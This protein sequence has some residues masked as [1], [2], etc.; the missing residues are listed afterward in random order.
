MENKAVESTPKVNNTAGLGTPEEY[1][2]QWG[3]KKFCKGNKSLEDEEHSGRPQKLTMTNWDQSLKLILI[4]LPK[5]VASE[6]NVNYSMIIWHLKQIGK[7]RKLDKCLPCELPKNKKKW[8]EVS[9]SLTTCN[10][11]KPFLDWIVTWWKVDFIRQPVMTSS[12]AGLRSSSKSL[13][14]AKLAPKK[15]HRH[16]WWSA[17]HLIHYSFP[18]PS[19]TIT[20]DCS[21]NRWGAPKTATPAA[22]TGHQKGPNSPPRQHLSAHHTTD[23]SKAVQTGLQSFAYLP[24]SLDL[25]PTDYHFKHLNG[26][27]QGKCFHSQQE[28]EN[29]FQEFVGSRGTDF[30]T[31]GIN[32]LISSW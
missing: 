7:V 26:F 21:A 2:V 31:T 5:K 30:Y 1:M 25:L 4:Q 18:N 11:N 17:A 15:G 14:I 6:L 13:P 20:S 16:S 32:K 12:V 9:S 8:F 3:F 29:A 23:A 24:Y 19:K 22:S 28:A 27:L 10:D